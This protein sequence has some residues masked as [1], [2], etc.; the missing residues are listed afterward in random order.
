LEGH[1][2]YQQGRA[3][4]LDETKNYFERNDFN[5]K[6]LK[7][8]SQSQ[9]SSTQVDISHCNSYLQLET[10]EYSHDKSGDGGSKYVVR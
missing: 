10:E 7:L 1:S 6:R 9:T 2:N 5:R 8:L 3:G 4:R